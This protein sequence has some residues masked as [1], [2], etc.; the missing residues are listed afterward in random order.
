MTPAVKKNA[1]SRIACA[2]IKSKCLRDESL[3]HESS[4][5]RINPAP[6]ATRPRVFTQPRPKLD[7]SLPIGWTSNLLWDQQ[8]ASISVQSIETA[9]CCAKPHR[10]TARTKSNS[11]FV[12]IRLRDPVKK[13]SIEKITE[14][15]VSLR[16]DGRRNAG[17]L[18]SKLYKATNPG[19]VLDARV[20]NCHRA[21]RR[22]TH[23]GLIPTERKESRA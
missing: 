4:Q 9:V 18:G 17:F 19:F 16:F 7:Y 5:S 6:P 2:T 8:P 20:G 1:G 3:V 13:A 10:S 21:F 22:C 11:R 14:A 12:G 15:L 23:S